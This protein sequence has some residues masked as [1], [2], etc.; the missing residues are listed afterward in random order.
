MTIRHPLWIAAIILSVAIAACDLAPVYSRPSTP[1]TP[2]YKE[3]A[4]WHAAKGNGVVSNDPWWSV[5]NDSTLNK[6]EAQTY[7]DN[8]NL[9]AAIANYDQARAILAEA[10]GSLFPQVNATGTAT[11]QRVSETTADAKSTAELESAVNG[12]EVA[13]GGK[14]L[15]TG[16][17]TYNDYNAGLDVS[18]DLDVFGR[19]RDAVAAAGHQVKASADDLAAL[20]LSLQAEV[21]QSYFMLR[22]DDAQIQILQQSLQAYQAQVTLTEGLFHDGIDAEEAVD[23]AR[24][25]L[26]NAKSSLDDIQLKRGQIEHALAVLV[27]TSPSGFT[28]APAPFNPVIVPISP[29]LPSQLLER[30]PDIAAAEQRVASANEEIGVARAA[31]FPDFTLTGSI[32]FESEALSHLISAPSLF[33]SL[34]PQVSQ[35]IFDGGEIAARIEGARAAYREAVANYRQ[36]VLTA[37]QNVEDNLASV[38]QY[39]SESKSRQSAVV[40]AGRALAQ[41]QSRY[42]AGIDTYLDVT[43]QE[44]A[45]LQEKLSL[46]QTQLS[47]VMSYILLIKALGGSNQ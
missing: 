23:E 21:A 18:Y 24:V 9:K 45:V 12:L 10:S 4:G 26:D 14:P 1:M 20:R 6:L 17:N 22:A 38:R 7:A 41:A 2:A 5:F 30:R 16:G 39:T 37:L 19:L 46:A 31:W 28:L 47:E 42:Y 35:S 33:W 3:S 11:R 25:Q 15:P 8:Q 36:S 32:G 29:G 34:G 27:G 40:D 43:T 13:S 44:N